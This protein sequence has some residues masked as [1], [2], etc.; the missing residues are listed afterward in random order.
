[1]RLTTHGARTHG[2][3]VTFIAP[4]LARDAKLPD[5]AGILAGASTAANRVT[6]RASIATAVRA[7]TGG[8]LAQDAD[9]S[10]ISELLEA[11]ESI[12]KEQDG[13]AEHDDDAIPMISDDPDDMVSRVLEFC[14]GKMSPEDCAQLEEL[15]GAAAE[16]A[17]LPREE[18]RGTPPVPGGTEESRRRAR[19]D[20]VSRRVDVSGNA[21]GVDRRSRTMRPAAHDAALPAGIKSA[22]E[23]F[24]FSR[25]RPAGNTWPSPAPLAYDAAAHDAVPAG[26]K[27]AELRFPGIA[28]RVKSGSLA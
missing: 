4:R 12:S 3:L 10:D 18:P 7:V 14:R 15:M 24:G 11:L 1:M 8:R 23:R 20:L 19:E 21:V 6:Q 17:Y 5:I 2:A 22:E 9:L 13:G 28:A 16:D 26:V 25:V 27:S